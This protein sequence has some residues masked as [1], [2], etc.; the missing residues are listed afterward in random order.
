VGGFIGE[1]YARW[2]SGCGVALMEQVPRG[3]RGDMGRGAC[4]LVMMAAVGALQRGHGAAV[5][6]CKRGGMGEWWGRRP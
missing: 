2:C 5:V 3:S 6:H 1:R 4:L